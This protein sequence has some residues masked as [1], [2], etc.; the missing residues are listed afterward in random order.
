M[1]IQDIWMEF[2]I[3]KCAKQIMWSRKWKMMEGIEL[4]NQEKIRRENQK[5]KSQALGNIKSGYHQ[6][7]RDERK[8]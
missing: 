5:G 1:Y 2:G 8:N 3:E 6:R 4:E 7:S